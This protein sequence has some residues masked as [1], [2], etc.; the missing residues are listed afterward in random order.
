MSIDPRNPFANSTATSNMLGQRSLGHRTRSWTGSDL[1]DHA[2]SFFR[3][4]IHQPNPTDD[5][6]DSTAH[7]RRRRRPRRR[8]LQ[9]ATTTTMAIE[10][11]AGASTVCR[12]EGELRQRPGPLHLSTRRRWDRTSRSE[13]SRCSRLVDEQ[14]SRTGRHLSRVRLKLPCG[15]ST[16]PSARGRLSVCRSCSRLCVG[17]RLG[18]AVYWGRFFG[19][20]LYFLFCRT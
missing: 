2:A 4:L 7:T 11:V 9:R 20:C 15:P 18:R 17:L 16:F 13:S 12:N 1:V 3:L 19:L 10:L 14:V 6:R 5:E 8:V